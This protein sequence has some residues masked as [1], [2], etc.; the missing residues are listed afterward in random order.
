MIQDENGILGKLSDGKVD[1]GD[2]LSN[3][4]FLR[5]CFALKD[6]LGFKKLYSEQVLDDASVISILYKGDGYWKRSP[7]DV[8]NDGK[9]T[10]SRDQWIM[11]IMY[12]ALSGQ[13]PRLVDT[14][15]WLDRNKWRY[16][17]GDVATGEVGLIVKRF[18]STGYWF[19]W[20]PLWVLDLW[21]LVGTFN[22]IGWVPRFKHDYDFGNGVRGKKWLWRPDADDCS[23]DKC[24]LAQLSICHLYS[25]TVVSKLATKLYFK[26][27]K[28]C[29]S[30]EN[31]L[32]L[33]EYNK[34]CNPLSAIYWYY[35]KP[36]ANEEIAEEWSAIALWLRKE[37]E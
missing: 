21:L 5:I 33:L 30:S 14:L 22:R 32:K 27:R 35:R 29:F 23:D 13:V 4:F 10:P 25:P 15:Q 37:F 18:L 19:K 9:F 7:E 36:E 28:P 20:L 16:P 1:T 6:R 31:Y 17:N 2:S 24:H 34:P 11:V 12:L 26:K 3:E 8:L